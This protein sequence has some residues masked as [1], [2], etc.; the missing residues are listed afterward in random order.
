MKAELERLRNE[1]A[2][3]KKGAAT[4]I[5]MK[6]SEKAIE[7]DFRMNNGVLALDMRAPLVGYALRRWS[8]DCSPVHKLDPKEHHLW[9]GK[10][11][12]RAWL[13]GDVSS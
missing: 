7:A 12:S 4:G 13:C 1:N 9:R 10:C 11:D 2:S 5:A 3:L 6:V 8:V